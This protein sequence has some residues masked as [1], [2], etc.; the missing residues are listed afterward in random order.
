MSGYADR[1][2]PLKREN[3]PTLIAEVA[4]IVVTA[5]EVVAESGQHIVNLGRADGDG[6]GNLNIQAPANQE[7]KRVVRWR[8]YAG[9]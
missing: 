2:F 5:S 1:V 8:S 3:N 4:L 6:F 7:V 9:S